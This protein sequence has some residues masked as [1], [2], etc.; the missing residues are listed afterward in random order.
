MIMKNKIDLIIDDLLQIIPLIKKKYLKIEHA[1]TV[2][3]G[4]SH[5]SMTIMS[6]LEHEELLPVSEI[7]RRL[8]ISK[9]Q[10]THLIDKLTQEGIVERLPDSSDRRVINI[11][12]TP[13]GKVK[14]AKD[15]DIIRVSIR[16]KLSCLADNELEELYVSMGKVRDISSRL[17]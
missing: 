10:M 11:R 1:E 17:E 16:K 2:S 6:M 15:K 5:R 13:R 4:V 14:L 7:G 12:L 9:P 3:R 8:L